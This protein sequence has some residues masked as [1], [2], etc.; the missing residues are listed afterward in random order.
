MRTTLTIEP[1]VA[2]KLKRRM[3]QTGISLKQTVND[4]LRRGLAETRRPT[5]PPSFRVEP[6]ASGFFPGIDRDRMNQLADQLEADGVL[7][8]LSR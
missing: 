4:A 2:Q 7:R 1:D 3:T 5:R 6:H 8:K